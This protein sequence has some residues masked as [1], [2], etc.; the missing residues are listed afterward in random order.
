MTL[1]SSSFSNDLLLKVREQTPGTNTTLHLDNCGSA[2]MPAPVI[3][4]IEA[5]LAQEIY[6]GGYV[7]QEQQS[8]ALEGAYEAIAGLLGAN[9]SEMALTGSAVEAWAKAFYSVPFE[10]GDNIVT[11]FNEY[12]SNFVSFLQ[13]RDRFGLEIRVARADAE[14]KLD[15]DHLESLVDSRTRLIAIA[16]VPSSSGQVNPVA[17]VGRV[18]RD[19]DVLYLLDACQAV[20]QMRVDVGEIGCH[21]LTGTSR[22]FLRGPRG[23]G[24]LY[25]QADTLKRLD[26]A[27]LSN[28]AAVWVSEDSYDL[29]ADA[30]V[31]EDWERSVVNQLGFGA[32]VKYLQQLGP[33][34]CFERTQA[35]AAYLREGLYGI[36]GVVGTCPPDATAAIV[37]FNKTGLQ[38]VDVKKRLAADGINV[39]VAN[40]IHTR[41]DLGARGIETTVRVSPHYYN[42]REEVDRFLNA[43]EAL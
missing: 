22:K 34:I 21:M 23:V 29:R 10:R 25:V 1:L 19:R 13:L 27:F 14:G 39:Q 9:R 40:V 4:A 7:A 15:V 11:A 28:Q 43:V 2:L 41:L 17:D 26:P 5:H 33:D 3:D 37:T 16:M 12:C 24:F 38:A 32:A 42:T 8:Q 30:G 6:H 36:K 35:M 31:F 20:G 18:A